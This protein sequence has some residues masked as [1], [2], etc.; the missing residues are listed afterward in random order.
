LTKWRRLAEP[1]SS[2]MKAA[3]EKIHKE[4][5]LSKDVYEVVHKSLVN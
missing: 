5:N 4:S 2:Q 1:N 3:L